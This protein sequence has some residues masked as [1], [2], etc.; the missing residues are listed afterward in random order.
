MKKLC[1]LFIAVLFMGSNSSAQKVKSTKSSN[2]G[3]VSFM[4]IQIKNDDGSSGTYFLEKGDKLVYHVTAGGNEYDFIV[5]LNSAGLGGPI[6]F[7]YQMTNASKTKGH[8][9][10]SS[11]ARSKA[12]KYINYFSGGDLNLTDASAVWLSSESYLDLPTKSTDMTFDD[13]DEE[14]FYRSENL[15]AEPVVKIKGKNKKLKVF[16]LNNS[17]DDDGDKTLWINDSES[18]PLIIKMKLGFTIELKEIR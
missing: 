2:S 5:T 16:L 12:T 1:I 14:S 7:N 8:I 3:E 13:G 6:D 11:D 18:N 9:N 10:I 4:P 15:E 17:A